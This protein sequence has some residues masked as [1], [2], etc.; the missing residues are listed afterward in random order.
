MSEGKGEEFLVGTSRN[1][2]LRGTF[3]DGFLV[4]VQVRPR[5]IIIT[6]WWYDAFRLSVS[7]LCDVFRVIQ[8]S[9]GAWP[10]IHLE[11]CFWP[12]LRTGWSASGTRWITVFNGAA[13]WKWG[14]GHWLTAWWVHYLWDIHRW[15]TALSLPQEHGH[16]ADFHPSGAVVTIGT[17]SGKSVQ[18]V[19]R[20][21]APTHAV[22]IVCLMSRVH[23]QLC[24][25]NLL[26][27]IWVKTS[28]FTFSQISAYE[29]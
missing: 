16:C 27:D 28:S 7:L 22:Q 26:T 13:C 14:R 9:C 25:F 4:E 20:S 11:R 18:I 6:A 23:S 5:D 19:C 17:H 3:N 2:I 24:V 12:V 21:I 10:L 1:F 8:T 29:C 15:L